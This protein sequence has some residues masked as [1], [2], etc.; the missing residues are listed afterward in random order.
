MRHDI[1]PKF[2]VDLKKA[3]WY[4]FNENFDLARMLRYEGDFVVGTS[5]MEKLKVI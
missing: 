2:Y 5:V 3:D 4:A 1:D